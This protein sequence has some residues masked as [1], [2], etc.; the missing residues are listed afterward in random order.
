L[1]ADLRI[2]S[3]RGIL[4]DPKSRTGE[5]LVMKHFVRLGDTVFDI[6]A[7]LGFY[8][9][10][11]SRLVG[12]SGR[13]FA[14]EP[15]R[16][17]LP[18]LGRTVGP[19]PNVEILNVALSDRKGEID[20]YVPQDASM[21]SLNNWTHGEVGEVHQVKCEMQILD[22]LVAERKL[23]LPDFIKCDVEG[24][25]YLIFK[26]ATSVLDREDAPVVLF[27]L[28]RKAALSF[29]LDTFHYIDLLKSLER[30]QF[31]FYEVL[32]DGIKRLDQGETEFANIV[33]IPSHRRH[34]AVEIGI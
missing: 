4:A 25:E 24:A 27:E 29:G 34:S 8:T 16:E 9:L 17:L 7:H 14:F 30:P 22:D 26:G 28:N 11:L 12:D 32:A 19:L 31:D 33:A 5:D 1:Y 6:G 15:N 18:S 21:A 2:A 20:L 23:P 13:V 10:L 3:A